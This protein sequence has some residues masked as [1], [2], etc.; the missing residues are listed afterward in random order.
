MTN[1]KIWQANLRAESRSNNNEEAPFVLVIE[2]PKRGDFA[3]VLALGQLI[4]ERLGG[5]LKVKRLKFRGTML[6]PLLRLAIWIA[7]RT[8][9]SRVLRPHVQL[10]FFRGDYVGDAKPIAVVSTLGRGEAQG[11][12]VRAFWGA[13]AI[14]LGS[15]KRLSARYFSAVVT[16][17]GDA[18][19]V[20][21]IPLFVAPTRVR[22]RPTMEQERT[23]EPKTTKICLLLGGDARGVASYNITFWSRCIKAAIKTA[24]RFSAQLTV[25]TSP[26]SGAL[27]E[28]VV[29]E[30]IQSE[31]QL[32]IDFINFGRGDRRDIVCE[33]ISADAVLVT[34]ESIS[35]MSDAIAAG[36][37]VVALYDAELPKSER[38]QKFLSCHQTAGRLRLQDLS[39]WDGEW[40][41]LSTPRPL[42][43]CWT[44]SLWPALEQVF[45]TGENRDR[46]PHANVSIR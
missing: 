7:S 2:D 3:N 9:I 22:L 19:K 32:A 11:A 15:T 33:I 24:G 28:A 35:M 27:V 18:A 39:D 43:T 37:R 34:A 41:D 45:S 14:H 20:N 30:A 44:E 12:F 10:A 13:P 46:N 36:A 21:E 5:T 16:H 42:S 40:L 4:S 25:S 8:G 38:I 26:R 17:A 31:P 6:L 1:N 23:S 29:D